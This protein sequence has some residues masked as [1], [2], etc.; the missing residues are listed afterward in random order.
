MTSRERLQ[1][2]AEVLYVLGGLDYDIGK[3]EAEPMAYGAVQLLVQRAQFV[4]PE[5]KL[6]P[7]EWNSVRRICQLTEGMPLALILA[8]GWLEMLTL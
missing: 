1:L 8:A 7:H 2:S 3:A 6:H 4:S 5:F